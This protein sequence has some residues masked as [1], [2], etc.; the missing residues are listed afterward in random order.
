MN[1]EDSKYCG[2]LYYSANALG[3]AMTRM[4]VEEFA[5]TGLSPSHAFLLM[6]VNDNPG[7]QPGNISNQMQLSPSTVTRLIEKM[8][9]KGFV[10]RKVAG[11]FTEVYPT[12]LS[13]QMD[14]KL[15]KAWA[16]LYKRYSGLLGE[17]AGKELTTLVYNAT[18][19]LNI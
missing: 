15:K 6:A 13:Q 4:A 7:I 16:N 3:R 14:M 8:E 18:K 11:K 9:S 1:N 19:T 12:N 2:C 5:I 10:E 17:D